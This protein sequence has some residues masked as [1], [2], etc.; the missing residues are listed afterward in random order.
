VDQTTWWKVGHIVA[1]ICGVIYM[2]LGLG[3]WKL[4]GLW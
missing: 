1:I 2:T 3:Y 4:L